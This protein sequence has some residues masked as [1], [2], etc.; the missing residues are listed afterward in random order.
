MYAIYLN[1]FY[2]GTKEMTKEE[3]RKAESQGFILKK[4]E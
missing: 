1:G 3:I 2:I 4:G